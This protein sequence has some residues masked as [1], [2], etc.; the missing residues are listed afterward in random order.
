MIP[1]LDSAPLISFS[2]VSTLDP[3]LEDA[4]LTRLARQAWRHNVGAGLTGRMVIR[5]REIRQTIEGGL[6]AVL[7]L[8][9]RILGDGRHFRI[10]VTC[11]GPIEARQHE[12]WR[13]LGLEAPGALGEQGPSAS[14]GLLRPE[15]VC[16]DAAAA[17]VRLERAAA[18]GAA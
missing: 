12:D 10:R 9:S 13:V 17:V 11:F 1:G 2:F 8:A 7:P 6:E 4:Q 18:G 5:G 16:T 3:D 15:F 14:A